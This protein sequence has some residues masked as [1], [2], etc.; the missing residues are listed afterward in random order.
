[1]TRIWEVI[2][3]LMGHRDMRVMAVTDGVEHW[4]CRKCLSHWTEYN[5]G[6]IK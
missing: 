6:G 5:V 2:C 1:M 3:R 4:V